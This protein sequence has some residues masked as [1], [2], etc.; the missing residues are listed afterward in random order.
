[1]D[2]GEGGAVP[3]QVWRGDAN[4]AEDTNHLS[5]IV[6]TGQPAPASPRPGQ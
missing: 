4:D 6:L 2:E 5:T 3:Q 1:V